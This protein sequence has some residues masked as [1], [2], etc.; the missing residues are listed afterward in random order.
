[1]ARGTRRAERGHQRRRGDGRPTLRRRA[2]REQPR[3]ALPAGQLLPISSVGPDGTIVLEDGSFVHVI[4]CY[5]RLLDTL[6]AGEI[7]QAFFNLQHLASFLQRGQVLQLN[8]ESDLVKAPTRMAVVDEQTELVYG[9]RPSLVSAQSA[10]EL[11]EAQRARWGLYQMLL[12]SLRRGATEGDFIPRRRVYL[13]PRYQP[14]QDTSESVLDAIPSWVPGSRQRT[15]SGPALTRPQQD[16][17]R[18]VLEHQRLAG[19][20]RSS[21]RG[22][23]AHLGRES[24]SGTILDGPAVLR[25]LRSRV[26][27][28]SAAWDRLEHDAIGGELLSTFDSPRERA[29]AERAALGVRELI[30]QSPLDF[31]RDPHHGDIEED[32]VRVLYLSGTPSVTRPFWLSELLNQPVPY[33][34]TVFLHGLDRRAIQED[35]GRQYHQAQRQVEHDSRK[36]RRDAMTIQKRDQQSAL[37]NEMAEDP[38]AGL[39]DMS[40]Y[41]A[42]RAP[43]PLPDKLGLGETVHQARQAIA[44]ATSGGTFNAGHK[45]QE[46]LWLSTLPL[47]V[48]HAAKTMRVGLEHAADSMPLIGSTCGSPS[49]LPLFVSPGTHEIQYLNPFDRSHTNATTI[50]C[51]RS[52]TGKTMQANRMLAQAVSLGAHGVVFDRAGHFE[53]LTQL[54]PGSRIVRLGH[55]D[56]DVINHWD[57]EDPARATREKVRFLV[58]LHRV[59]L[60]RALTKHE[61]A[62]LADAIRGTYRYCARTGAQPREG[63][64][65][66]L[67]R[68]SAATL[69][70]TGGEGFLHQTLLGLIAELGEYVGDGIHAAMWDRPTTVPGDTPLLIFDYSAVATHALTPLI[71]ATMEWTRLRVQRI[72]RD[73]RKQP[74][75]G[76]LFHGRSVVLLDEGHAWARVPELAG[77]VQMWARESRRWGAWFLVISQDAEDFQGDARAV[78]RNATL[79]IFFQ[80]DPGMLEFLEHALTLSAETIGRLANLRSV[81]G[82]YSEAFVMNG[83]RGS[84]RVLALLGASE[85]WAFTSEPI[86]DVPARERTI[87]KH[88]GDV[89]AAI[90]EL[91]AGG[92]PQIEEG[93]LQ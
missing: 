42:L 51:G 90:A 83:T 16:V 9:F 52:G 77:E 14:N 8:V 82:S 36:G 1:M 26:N 80:Q 73:A 5:P 32:L 13:L 37:V 41:L 27:P 15:D 44:R 12:E 87:A 84:G 88:Q 18:T 66:A 79:R 56:G 19:R 7:E 21:A 72:D 71:F 53:L 11:T 23:I 70:P 59:L 67:M 89:W 93:T 57:V 35:A 76:R 28:T 39:I 43:G 17:R 46:A 48:D 74:A 50:I 62:A 45:Q 49:G 55:S 47:G 25:Y 92:I 58:D 20:A 91:A 75:N 61:D 31:R 30:A 68:A 38:Q 4:A 22:L 3:V 29:E 54:I 78:L 24:M 65:V 60:G 34:L 6:T 85:Y 86:H 2:A 40:V 64:L 81:K 63:E 10:G 33:T 69:G